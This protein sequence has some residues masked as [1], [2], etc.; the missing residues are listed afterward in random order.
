[1]R[2]KIINLETK[3][4]QRGWLA[5]LLHGRDLKNKEFGQ[6]LITVAKPG[7][8]KGGHYHLRKEE[9]FIVISGRGEL[10]FINNKTREETKIILDEKKLK[11]VQIP[12]NTMHWIKNLG[13]KDLH[14]LAYCNEE[15]NPE[16]T[17]TFIA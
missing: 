3:K 14:L 9:W 11:A 5:E 13:K 2:V 4:D 16:D 8:T 1:M 12:L 6:L 15:F 7:I 10:K 17:D